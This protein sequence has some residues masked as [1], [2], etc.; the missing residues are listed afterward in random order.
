[1]SEFE[2][3][4]CWIWPPRKGPLLD[5]IDHLFEELKGSLKNAVVSFTI[6]IS[7][8]FLY[9]YHEA[10]DFWLPGFLIAKLFTVEI[11]CYNQ[12][13]QIFKNFLIFAVHQNIP[14]VLSAS[15]ILAFNKNDSIHSGKW[16][17]I[18]FACRYVGCQEELFENE[19]LLKRHIDVIKFCKVAKNF[20][21]N[22]LLELIWKNRV[23]LVDRFWCQRLNVL[24]NEPLW[25][26]LID[27]RYVMSQFPELLKFQYTEKLAVCMLSRKAFKLRYESEDKF[28]TLRI[29]L[30]HH[31]YYFESISSHKNLRLVDLRVYLYQH[32]YM[33]FDIL[34][35]AQ[36]YVT[37]FDKS[38]TLY[39]Q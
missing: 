1:M 38:I 22:I 14:H 23:D 27:C 2:I 3:G 11:C 28:T 17:H 8:V 20:I 9:F 4:I 35:F 36:L 21:E 31:G 37:L 24:S 34:T 16:C 12:D 13:K 5:K 15:H 29:S 39:A 26:R 7:E 32:Q 30:K 25:K 18:N 33:K 19:E 10:V 6:S